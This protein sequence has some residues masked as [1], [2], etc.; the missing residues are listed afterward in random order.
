ML[1]LVFS[2]RVE[3]SHEVVMMKFRFSLQGMKGSVKVNTMLSYVIKT[4]V[5]YLFVYYPYP[6]DHHSV[7]HCSSHLLP[8]QCP[9]L[10]SII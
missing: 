9:Q 10:H 3:V 1:D 5:Y 8:L 2:V 7:L 4:I 6:L